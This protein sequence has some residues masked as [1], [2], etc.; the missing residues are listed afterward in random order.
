MATTDYLKIELETYEK[1]RQILSQQGIGRFALI[2]GETVAGVW[3]TYEDAL[4]AGY[5][6]FG[7]DA[8]FLVKRIQG[9]VD[10]IQFFS[11]DLTCPA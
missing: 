1:N 7:V 8:R 6:K 9:P 5:E 4:K 11:R 3:G 10:G 2:Q